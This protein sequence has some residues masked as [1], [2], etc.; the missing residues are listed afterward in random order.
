MAVSMRSRTVLTRR[1]ILKSAAA[2]A[3]ITAIG[4][5]A[6]PSLSVAPDRAQITHGIQSGDVRASIPAWSGRAPTG[7][8]A[9][10]SKRRPPTAFAT[11]S[12]AVYVDALPESGL[13]RQ[14]CCWK[15]CRPVRRSS[16]AS[17]SRICRRAVF[18]EAAGRAFPHAAGRTPLGLVRVV[19]RHDGPGL[20]HRHG[21]RRH[22]HLCDHAAQPAGFLHPFAATTSMPTARLPPN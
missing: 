19:G 12:S 9:C 4:G 22:A 13:H 2:S 3:A 7:R 11:S 6:R 1:T 10:W 8:R 16:T 15:T 18:G 20:G 17:A 14:R 5:I 21:T